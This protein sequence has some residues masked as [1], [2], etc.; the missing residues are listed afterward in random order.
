M[1]MKLKH[2]HNDGLPPEKTQCLTNH[3]SSNKHFKRS[4]NFD[5]RLGYGQTSNKH[6]IL[7]CSAY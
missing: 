1:E 4:Y 3:I 7:R 2:F 5:V 6:W